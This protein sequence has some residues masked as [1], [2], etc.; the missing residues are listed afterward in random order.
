[1]EKR[2]MGMIWRLCVALV[3]FTFTAIAVNAQIING[4]FETAGTNYTFPD[5]GDGAFP[6]ISNTFAQNWNPNG[7]YVA[8]TATNSPQQGSYEEAGGIGQDWYGIN[9]SGT[10]VS[11][12]GPLAFPVTS[13][14]GQYSLRTFGPFGATCCAGSGAVQLLSSNQNAAVSN[15]TVWVVSGYGFNWSGDPLNRRG[16][17]NRWVRADSGCLLRCHKRAY[18]YTDRWPAS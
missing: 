11:P 10:N 13:R 8:R 1:M 12:G 15:N 3:A 2:V 14:S 18:W 16:S 4:G 5:A 17:R 7:S 6:I 9:Q